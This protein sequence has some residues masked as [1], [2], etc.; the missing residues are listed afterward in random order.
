VHFGLGDAT[1][2]AKLTVRYPDGTTKRLANVRGN[3][4]VTVE[5]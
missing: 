4:I 2:V 5:R 3:R 1:S